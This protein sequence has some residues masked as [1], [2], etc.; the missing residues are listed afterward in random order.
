MSTSH[1]TFKDLLHAA[2]LRHGTDGFTS[3][4]N[5]GVLRIFS[6]LKIRWLRPGLNPQTWV[7]EASPLTPRPP[8][9]CICYYILIYYIYMYRWTAVSMVNMFQDL[10][11]LRKTMDNTKRYM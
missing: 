2:N 8:K 6:P 10:P 7:P 11:Q 9:P 1:A 4:P 3:P 5:E